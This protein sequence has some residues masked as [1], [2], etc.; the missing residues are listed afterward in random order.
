MD[1]R[2]PERFVRVDVS[3]AGE[4]PLV[5]QRRLDRRTAR[6]QPL[7]EAP[8]GEGAR[9]W[10]A[11]DACSKVRLQLVRLDDQPRAETPH[12]AVRDVR[13]VV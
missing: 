3:H 7:A 6:A 4:R 2:T 1:P 10:L 11:A 13:P 12:V 9:E 8:G 5:K